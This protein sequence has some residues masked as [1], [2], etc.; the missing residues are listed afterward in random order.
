MGE[1]VFCWRAAMRSL[2]LPGTAFEALIS[3]QH[4]SQSELIL[5]SQIK[6][7]TY[8]YIRKK[9]ATDERKKG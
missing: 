3:P 1:E 6:D 7:K 8:I 9:R 2:R 4:N 5:K